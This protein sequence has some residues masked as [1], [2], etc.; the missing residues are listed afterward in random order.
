VTLALQRVAVVGAT[1]PTGIHLARRL[2]ER[3]IAV[4]AVSR[5]REELERRFA[6]EGVE[7]VA[8]DA[9]DATATR[10]AVAGCDL[11]VDAVGLPAE[12][13]ADH[14][15]TARVIAGAAAA[16]GARCLQISSYWSFL[17]HRRAVVDE[18]H[19]RA[20]GH[21]WFRWRREAEDVILGAGGAVVHLPDFFGPDVHTGSVQLALREA[22]AGRPMPWFGGAD[23]ARETGFVP[24]LMR[25]VADLA[26]REEA[27]GTDWAFPGS[28]PISGRGLARLAAAHLGRPVKVR[29]APS[30][31]LMALSLVNAELRQARPIISPYGR[32]V[33]YDAAKLRGL[34][35]E[36]PVTPYEAAVPATLDWLAGPAVAA[37]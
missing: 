36:L 7:V 37:P 6:G 33:R 1:G 25:L 13:M 14:P 11:V 24:D 17:P 19:P 23:V 10:R 3:G 15:R 22:R 9:L 32:P 2:G 21:P 8:A 31:L 34:L 26:V 30:W 20:G 28:G 35:G 5:R 27:Y 12:R 16:A 29:A 18:A 4:R